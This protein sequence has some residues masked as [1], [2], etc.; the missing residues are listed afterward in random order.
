MGTIEVPV[1]AVLFTAVFVFFLIG[2]QFT[3]HRSI[4]RLIEICREQD[5]AFEEL[6]RELETALKWYGEQA[7]LARLVHSEGDAGRQAL[8]ADGGKKAKQLL[9]QPR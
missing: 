3:Q 7:R 2:M 8:A 5:K 6:I 4:Q 1:L 9:E